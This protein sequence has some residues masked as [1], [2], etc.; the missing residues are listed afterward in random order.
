MAVAEL[1]GAG[2]PLARHV[3]GFAPR[4]QQQAMAD[5]VADALENH[6][7]LVVEAGTGIGKTYAYLVPALLCGGKII[8]STGTRNLQD[9][10]YHKDLPVVRK[11]LGVSNRSAMLKGRSN[12][13]CQ[14]RLERA[15]D[16]KS[17]V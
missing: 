8:I 17:V 9:Q 3:S 15:G 5:A 16:R 2:G 13:L 14:H 11:A 1:L 10:L 6:E 4:S 12:Y 7:V